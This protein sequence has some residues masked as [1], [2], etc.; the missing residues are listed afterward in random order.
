[1]LPVT[2]FTD[3]IEQNSLF[4]TGSRVLAAVSGGMDS[5]LMAHLLKAAGFDFAIA[6]CN[7]QLRSDESTRDEQFCQNLANQLG[8]EFHVVKFDTSAY[9][10]TNK[11]SI[12]MA[13]RNMRYQWF[14][15][16]RQ[17]HN[18]DVVALAHHQN[19]SIE[20]ILLNLTR[21]TGI[22]GLHGILPKNGVLVRPLMFLG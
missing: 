15:Q 5:V 19:D 7:F 21:G 11:I 22:A 17:Q 2:R 1:M 9:A 10:A 3:F 16:L 4:T 14:E 13:A 20:T 12:Q 18:Y 6:H 8:V